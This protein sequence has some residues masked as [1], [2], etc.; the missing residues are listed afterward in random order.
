[1]PGPVARILAPLDLDEQASPALAKAAAIAKKEGSVLVLLHVIPSEAPNRLLARAS[2]AGEPGVGE[3]FALEQL[4]LLARAPAAQGVGYEV[5]V[6]R[7][8]PAQKILDTATEENVDLIVLS[9]RRDR[10]RL[11]EWL[12]GSTAYDVVRHASTNVL[13]VR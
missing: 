6:T 7:G 3:E 13:V 4:E 9:D 12:L 10:S 8:N 11:R 1:M 2:G 5:R